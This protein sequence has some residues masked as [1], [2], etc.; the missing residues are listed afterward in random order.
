MTRVSTKK[1]AVSNADFFMSF[2][3]LLRNC[4]LKGEFDTRNVP[5]IQFKRS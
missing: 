4:L 3:F 5:V 1:R 2:S